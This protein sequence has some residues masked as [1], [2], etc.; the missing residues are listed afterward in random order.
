MKIEF[1]LTRE[2][3]NDAVPFVLWFVALANVLVM[4]FVANNGWNA[5]AAIVM[6]L[7]AL[8]LPPREEI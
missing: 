3:V 1:E 4:P 6:V 7:A 8:W 2:K 5:G